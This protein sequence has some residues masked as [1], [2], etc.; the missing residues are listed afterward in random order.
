MTCGAD[1]LSLATGFGTGR[2]D[3]DKRKYVIRF[4]IDDEYL[5]GAVSRRLVIAKFGDMSETR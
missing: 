5:R 2:I 1:A 3:I 4:A